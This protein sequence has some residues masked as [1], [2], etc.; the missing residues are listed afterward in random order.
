MICRDRGGARLEAYVLKA[1]GTRNTVTV[2]YSIIYDC[3]ERYPVCQARQDL[4]GL[5]SSCDLAGSRQTI[6]HTVQPSLE[7]RIGDDVAP[8]EDYDG[9]HTAG[10][11][12]SEVMPDLHCIPAKL[13][14]R[15]T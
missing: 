10:L 9:L 2:C 12:Q 7:L 1:R 15:T 13:G 5:A 14:Y 4:R 11:E 6:S 3:T 8:V